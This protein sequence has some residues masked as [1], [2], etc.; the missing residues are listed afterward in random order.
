MN[1]IITFARRQQSGDVCVLIE[2]N[3]EA[4]HRIM[5]AGE[6]AHR[7][8]TRIVAHKHF[9]NLQDRPELL[10]ERLC[11]NM[12]QIE[13]D[14]ILAIHAHA[15]ET[16]LEDF[17]CG[18]VARH[19]VAVGGILLFEKIPAFL[20]GNRGWRSLVAFP[21]WDPDAAA[22]AAR[23]LAHQTQLVVAGDRRR[24]HLDEFAVG[25]PGPLLITSRDGAAR[26]HH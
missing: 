8:V 24:M 11:R 15:V 19:Q 20:F 17:T 25:V 14:L 23:R 12:G 13:E 10:I 22:F 2:I 5:D 1:R 9:V 3:P 7:H 6:D 16:D 21:A 18:N 4:A 26:A